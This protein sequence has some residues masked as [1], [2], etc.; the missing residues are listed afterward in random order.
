MD[1]LQKRTNLNDFVAKQV[2][3]YNKICPFLWH[4]RFCDNSSCTQCTVV[5][6]VLYCDIYCRK[7]LY[8]VAPHP[9][10]SVLAHIIWNINKE[11]KNLRDPTEIQ[12]NIHKI[13]MAVQDLA[14]ITLPGCSGQWL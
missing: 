11:K 7:H 2:G 4:S 13:H 12:T 8:V 9:T 1:V 3:N 5:Y 14:V 6:C 10:L